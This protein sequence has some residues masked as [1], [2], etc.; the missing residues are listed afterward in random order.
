MFL[1]NP[2]LLSMGPVMSF[3]SDT[4]IVPTAPAFLIGAV[5]G[6]LVGLALM[7][8]GAS[9]SRARRPVLRSVIGS[10]LGAVLFLATA[11]WWPLIIGPFLTCPATAIAAVLFQR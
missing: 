9:L 8:E 4:N 1:P 2:K 3:L 7:G 5:L 10:A 11:S 6:A